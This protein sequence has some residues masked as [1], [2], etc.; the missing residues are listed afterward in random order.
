MELGARSNVPSG[1]ERRVSVCVTMCGMKT[2]ELIPEWIVEPATAGASF[3]PPP[4]GKRMYAISFDLDLNALKRT[5]PG[6]AHTNAY[7]EIRRILGDEGFLWMQGSVYFGGDRIDAV[8]CVLA[9][10]RLARELSW[11]TAAVRDIRMLRIEDNN[12][13]GPAVGIGPTAR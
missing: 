3:A 7:F 10:Q 8:T 9:A 11:F 1:D 4:F 2:I 6:S 5:Y 12:D 13:L